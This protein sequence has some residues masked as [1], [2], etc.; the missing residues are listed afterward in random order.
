MR[1][2]S[3]RRRAGSLEPLLGHLE[4]EGHSLEPL[5]RPFAEVGYGRHSKVHTSRSSP[6]A[7][8]APRPAAGSRMNLCR[9]RRPRACL[10]LSKP[11]L[12]PSLQNQ[13][14]TSDVA[15][16]SERRGRRS[17]ALERRQRRGRR[18]AQECVVDCRS[19]WSIE[20][21]KWPS[22]ECVQMAFEAT[23]SNFAAPPT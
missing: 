22:T 1:P 7:P 3:P 21:V 11:A 23:A 12:Q 4:H 10:R 18:R 8:A 2:C 17:G 6:V 13:V 19:A 14:K 16:P 9:R 15:R 20:C 5:A